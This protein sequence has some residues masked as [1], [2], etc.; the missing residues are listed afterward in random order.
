MALARDCTFE[1]GV[2]KFYPD[3]KRG[4]SSPGEPNGIWYSVKVDLD[5][6]PS[7]KVDAL[8]PFSGEEPWVFVDGPTDSPHRYHVSDKGYIR[9]C[10]WYPQD[11]PGARWRFADGLLELLG[12]ART[13]LLR[14]A[15]YRED[16]AKCGTA[17]WLGPEAPHSPSSSPKGLKGYR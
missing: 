11:P 16:L 8:V 2:F 17:E 10:M 14:E 12:Y 6:F 5:R 7:R 9:L 13:H 15:F 1:R 4:L 3:L